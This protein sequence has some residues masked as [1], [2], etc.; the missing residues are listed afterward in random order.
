MSR[1]RI[2]AKRVSV[3]SCRLVR[4]SCLLYG[5]RRI[6]DPGD[7]AG[8]AGRFLADADR[9]IFLAIC[10]NTKNEPT[11]V[12]TVSVGTLNSSCVHPREL[13]K[14]AILSN[15]AGL[16]LAH[17]HPSGD[18]TPSREDEEVTRRLAEAGRLL[19]IE[20][21]D[22]VIVGA[23]GSFLSMKEKGLLVGEGE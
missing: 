15:A 5:N 12:G 6:R 11:A 10:L 19:G 13:F 22:H 21:L 1:K 23:G 3:V 17:N 2:P 14:F 9:E 18:P 20:V 4:E 16:I 8:L 7:A